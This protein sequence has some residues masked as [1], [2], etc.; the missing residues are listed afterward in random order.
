MIDMK[1]K[2]RTFNQLEISKTFVQVDAKYFRPTEVDLL[3]RNPTKA[4]IQ[5][6]WMPKYDLQTMVH[7]MMESNLKLS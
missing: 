5:L 1:I 7:K 4:I 2:Y 3:I 6:D